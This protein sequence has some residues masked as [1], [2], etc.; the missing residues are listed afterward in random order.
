MYRSIWISENWVTLQNC[1]LSTIPQGENVCHDFHG[2]SVQLGSKKEP[3][4]KSQVPNNSENIHLWTDSI[5]IYQFSQSY[6][7]IRLEVLNCAPETT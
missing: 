5:V 4:S 1:L 6:R 7:I 3:N 2:Q